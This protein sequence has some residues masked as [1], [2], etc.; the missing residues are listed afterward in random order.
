MGEVGP[1]DPSTAL[2]EGGGQE[3]G[4]DWRWEGAAFRE[5]KPC[6]LKQV[7]GPVSG[8]LGWPHNQPVSRTQALA[9]LS[10]RE[11]GCS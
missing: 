11:E 4:Q 5:S 9:A 1:S 6:H 8:Q 2:Q 7:W 3:E 10:L